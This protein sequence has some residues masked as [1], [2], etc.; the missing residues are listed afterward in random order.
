MHQRLKTFQGQ[1]LSKLGLVLQL[2]SWRLDTT[3]FGHA[4]SWNLTLKWIPSSHPRFC[5]AI[6]RRRFEGRSR[7]VRK[8][9]WYEEQHISP[10]LSKRIKNRLT[11]PKHARHMVR[12]FLSVQRRRQSTK[13]S[14]QQIETPMA[15]Q[16]NWFGV[17]ITIRCIALVLVT[18]Y[19]LTHTGAWRRTQRL[20]GKWFLR[21]WKKWR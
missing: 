17:H 5:C 10:S 9:K 21:T 15:L 12:A 1:F 19:V 6:V 4:S 3:N 8:G 20:K 11:M 13:K 18:P 16:R 14:P 2:E 7:R